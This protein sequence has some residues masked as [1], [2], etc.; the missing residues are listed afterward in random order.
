MFPSEDAMSDP[1]HVAWYTSRTWD[2]FL[3]GH[4]MLLVYGIKPWQLRRRERLGYNSI[5]GVTLAKC[6]S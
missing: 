5:L 6:A 1:T 3:E 2:Y 4:P